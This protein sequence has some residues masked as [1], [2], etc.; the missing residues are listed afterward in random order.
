M[1]WLRQHFPEIKQKII[2]IIVSWMD[3]NF[4]VKAKFFRKSQAAV[5]N[6]RSAQRAG[7]HRPRGNLSVELAS[8]HHWALPYAATGH[9]V[10]TSPRFYGIITYM[11]SWSLAIFLTGWMT[12][13]SGPLRILPESESCTFSQRDAKSKSERHISKAGTELFLTGG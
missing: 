8:G 6:S 13:G 11:C 5:G 10:I 9:A 1:P 4:S 7:R 3:I 2:I 12:D